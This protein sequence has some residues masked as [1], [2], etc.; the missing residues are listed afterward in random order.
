MK[1]LSG[2]AGGIPSTCNIAVRAPYSKH[3]EPKECCTVGLVQNKQFGMQL[4]LETRQFALFRLT[5]LNVRS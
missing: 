3:V 1:T 4:A 5:H 2:K